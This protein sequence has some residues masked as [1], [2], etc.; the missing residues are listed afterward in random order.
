[1]EPPTHTSST[2]YIRNSNVTLPPLVN[3]EQRPRSSSGY[4]GHTSGSSSLP[5]GP[6]PRHASHSSHT[7]TLPPISTSHRYSSSSHRRNTMSVDTSDYNDSSSYP[8]YSQSSASTHHS[9]AYHNSY[10]ATSPTA[11][12]A[13][14]CDLCGQT[15]SRAYDCKRHR[16]IHTRQGGHECPSCHKSLSRADALKRHMERGCSGTGIDEEDVDENDRERK[17]RRDKRHS[18]AADGHGSRYYYPNTTTRHH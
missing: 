6:P 18:T 3:P 17:D 11:S 1:M 12:R 8:L 7:S 16:D 14:A 5:F 10:E 2:G 9:T 13:F 15:F 4:P